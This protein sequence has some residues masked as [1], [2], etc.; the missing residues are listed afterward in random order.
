MRE[1]LSDRN[2][3]RLRT[4]LTIVATAALVAPAAAL[5][6]HGFSD[7]SSS[8]FY[9]AAVDWMKDNGVT[10]GCNPPSNTKYCPEGNVTRGEMAV[11]LERLDSKD[12]FVRPSEDKVDGGNAASLQNFEASDL[13]RAGY[14]ED[15]T[16]INDF[17]DSTPTSI[18]DATAQAPVNGIL[19]VW[20]NVTAERDFDST[21]NTQSDLVLT[22]EVD[23]TQ[24]GIAAE[25]AF[26]DYTNSSN[27]SETVAI[28]AAIPVSAGT[29][30]VD[31]M[32]REEG[33]AMIFIE[34]RSLTTMFVPFGDSGSQTALFQSRSSGDTA[35][36][37]D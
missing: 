28:S 2:R 6:T 16:S 11:F 10:V 35:A 23:G 24:A 21:A 34:D 8:K 7:V 29:H 27:S 31:L 13:G 25:Q 5:A 26:I 15:L 17:D 37:N 22:I 19:M 4:V 14:T 33:G 12:V 1:R 9:H 20:G 32:A 3:R 36:T 18:L 30:D